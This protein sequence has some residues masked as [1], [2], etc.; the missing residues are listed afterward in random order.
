MKVELCEAAI[1]GGGEDKQTAVETE[2]NL[3]F[4]Y[5]TIFIARENIV[6]LKE[7]GSERGKEEG[8]DGGKEKERRKHTEGRQEGARDED[9]RGGGGER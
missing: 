1:T 2:G 9:K 5:F 4:F 3:Y 6:G 8:E 7:R